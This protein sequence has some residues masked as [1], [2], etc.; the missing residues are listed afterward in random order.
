MDP[1]MLE[2]WYSILDLPSWVSIIF[3]L[4]YCQPRW[5]KVLDFVESSCEPPFN[6]CE[7]YCSL[8]WTAVWGWVQTYFRYGGCMLLWRTEFCPWCQRRPPWH[9]YKQSMLH[10]MKRH[11]NILEA[12]PSRPTY[13]CHT[14]LGGSSFSVW[15]EYVISMT[16]GQNYQVIDSQWLRISSQ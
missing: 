4:Y 2:V 10:P 15:N 11:Q 9:S 5:F 8:W 13:K 3:Y 16:A 12:L 6:F 14:D 1:S 7:Q